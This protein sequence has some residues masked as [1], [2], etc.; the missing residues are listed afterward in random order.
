MSTVSVIMPAYNAAKYIG[1]AIDSLL[2][3]SF[4]DWELILVN[5]GSSDE[6]LSIAQS[7]SDPRIKITSQ[8]NQGEAGARNTGLNLAT[9]KYISFL[10]ADDLYLPNALDSFVGYMEAHP[11]VAVAYSDGFICNIAGE[12]LMRLTEIRAGIAEGFILESVVLS[13]IIITVPLCTVLR[14]TAVESQKFR[15]DQNLGYGTDWDFWIRISR[16]VQFGYLDELT[17]KYRVHQTNMTRVSGV[18]KQRADLLAGRL[19]VLNAD[20]FDALSIHT[21]YQFFYNLLILL[22]PG[23]LDEQK[24]ILNSSQFLGLPKEQQALILRMVA[25]DYILADQEI[26]FAIACLQQSAA[27]NP[28]DR[29]SKYLSQLISANPSLARAALLGWR[30]ALNSRKKLNALLGNGPKPVP[31]ELI[32][33]VT[34][35]T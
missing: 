29:K 14:R 7:Y 35:Q 13:T 15:F 34:V 18:A 26:D 9:G 1:E 19:K 16:F 33:I 27:N 4:T 12:P 21:Q 24:K 28:S 17:C 3:Q 22:L 5:D 30:T 6:T 20:W 25:T 10:D 23:Q 31:V 11:D 2:H 8:A 32:P